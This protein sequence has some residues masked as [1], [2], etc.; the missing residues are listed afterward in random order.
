M[1]TLQLIGFITTCIFCSINA[2]AQD[3][4]DLDKTDNIQRYNY[5][6]G[7]NPKK[8]IF[9]DVKEISN[10][11]LN[12]TKHNNL[13][14]LRIE[15]CNLGKIVIDFNLNPLLQSLYISNTKFDTL[16]FIGIPLHFVQLYIYD[17]HFNS[18]DFLS[19]LQSLKDFYTSD[20]KKLDI[21]NLVDNL[22]KL[23][24]LHS[25]GISEGKLIRLPESF[26]RFKKLEWLSL[27]YMDSSF[28]LA[29]VF[30]TIQDVEI[31]NIS[32]MGCT[33]TIM[34]TEIKLLKKIKFLGIVSTNFNTLPKEIGELTQLEEISASMSDLDSL[35][36]SFEKL[37][38]LR[39]LSLI[40]C[41]FTSIP[42]VLYKMT[43]LKELE[44]GN[45]DWFPNNNELKPLRTAL[46]GCVVNPGSED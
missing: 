41:K 17:K 28:D 20:S 15:K 16:I 1:K 36:D 30:V 39:S 11:E 14:V 5:L 4:I 31:T 21:E 12:L 19:Q 25:I 3:L 13:Q 23:P 33:N 29:S 24:N 18:F 44:I 35:P 8:I 45:D 2:T 43:W 34:P 9:L 6:E 7:K 46:K 27:T 22:L 40:P 38:K 26:K 42:L 32:L 37:I 10:K